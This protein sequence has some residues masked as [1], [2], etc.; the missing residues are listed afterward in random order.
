MSATL[1]VMPRQKEPRFAVQ[2]GL[3][4][5]DGHKNVVT[6]FTRGPKTTLVRFMSIYHLCENTLVRFGAQIVSRL[7]GISSPLQFQALIVFGPNL[8]AGKHSATLL[9]R[10]CTLYSA[11]RAFL[12]PQLGAAFVIDTQKSLPRNLPGP[13]TMQ[14]SLLVALRTFCVCVCSSSPPFRIF[15]E[16]VLQKARINNQQPS[17]KLQPSYLPAPYPAIVQ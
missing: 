4:E 9:M 12:R 13:Q 17:A 3:L 16:L 6:R 7:L 8:R 15:L 14:S 2:W 10:L 11:Q 5:R 1:A